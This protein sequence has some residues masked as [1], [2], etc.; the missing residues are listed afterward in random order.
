MR[1]PAR[2]QLRLKNRSSQRIRCHAILLKPLVEATRLPMRL[3]KFRQWYSILQLGRVTCNKLPRNWS[4]SPTTYKVLSAHLKS[5]EVFR[6]ESSNKVIPTWRHCHFSL[7][8]EVVSWHTSFYPTPKE[9]RRS[10]NFSL[11]KA[12]SSMHSCVAPL[13]SGRGVGFQKTEETYS[14]VLL[15]LSG[16]KHL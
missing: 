8:F 2:L 10:A 6:G 15:N 1:F 7:D 13:G 4:C 14:H 9:Q 16:G 3:P 11:L 5:K 12:S